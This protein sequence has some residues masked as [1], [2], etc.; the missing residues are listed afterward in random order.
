MYGSQEIVADEQMNPGAGIPRFRILVH[1]VMVV[2]CDGPHVDC[3]DEP[4][5]GDS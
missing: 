3:S 4:P 2:N 1:T 5:G